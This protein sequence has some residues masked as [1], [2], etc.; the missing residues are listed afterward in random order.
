MMRTPKDQKGA[1]PLL[2]IKLL[3]WQSQWNAIYNTGKA[4]GT[5]FNPLNSMIFGGVWV[6]KG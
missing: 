3:H 2:T 6:V 4:S 1:G 5:Q